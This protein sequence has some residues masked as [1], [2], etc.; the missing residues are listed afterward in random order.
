MA[1]SKITKAEIA[2]PTITTD[3]NG[4]KVTT[5]A[6]GEKRY[7]RKHSW[8]G[9]QVT[10]AGGAAAMTVLPLPVGIATQAALNIQITGRTNGLHIIP[11]STDTE[12]STTLN[13][14]GLNM[15]T[16]QTTITRIDVNI[17]AFEV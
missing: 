3:A 6:S 1:E 10:G 12:T 15:A 17:V 14:Y 2:A 16:T 11:T 9:S 13:L 4:W 8:T 7:T 5:F